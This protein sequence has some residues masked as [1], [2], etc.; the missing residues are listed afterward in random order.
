M[1][2]MNIKLLRF[3]FFIGMGVF[4]HLSYGQTNDLMA[5]VPA[6]A[7]SV[8]V[9]NL[10]N[11]SKK[12]SWESVKQL[13]FF[14]D[15]SSKLQMSDRAFAE[16]LQDPARSGVDFSKMIYMIKTAPDESGAAQTNFLFSLKD[17][18]AFEKLVKTAGQTAGI[19]EKT[20]F[21]QISTSKT[22]YIRVSAH[23]TI[24]PPVSDGGGSNMDSP[25]SIASAAPDSLTDTVTTHTTLAWNS[26]MATVNIVKGGKAG[27]VASFFA[28]TT[29]T[30]GAVITDLTALMKTP[31]DVYNRVDFGSLASNAKNMPGMGAAAGAMNADMFKGD[32]MIG[33]SDF[34]P[35][36]INSHEEFKV[37]S[38]ILGMVAS[39]FKPSTSANF[40]RYFDPSTVSFA[41]SLGVDVSVL[42][43]MI[44]PMMGG[45]KNKMG[46]AASPEDI[47]DALD[48]DIAVVGMKP[49]DP[50]DTTRHIVMAA[51]LKDKDAAMKIL[52]AAVDSGSM[53][54]VSDG[55][56]KMKVPKTAKNSIADK[57]PVKT[58][59]LAVKND[60]VF[61]GEQNDLAN[62]KSNAPQTGANAQAVAQT[63]TNTAFGVFAN[64]EALMMMGGNNNKNPN[65][66]AALQAL[67]HLTMTVKS[68]QS[69]F[70]VSMKDQK[71]NSLQS[72]L[73]VVDAL[74]AAA[75]KNKP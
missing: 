5:S 7:A 57:K 63:L 39:A 14:K 26:K 60:V 21:K 38:M 19:T 75:S 65:L 68:G 64:I 51:S 29:P 46:I 67:D 40:N 70:I 9:I 18:S 73:G 61:F 2:F 20:G 34:E 25:K 62:I 49:T 66:T 35:G 3:F 33:T 12:V 56:Y 27:E 71:T 48:G 30:A 6:S 58:S 16:V 13:H 59:Y 41:A 4:A 47:M 24:E 28:N 37:N 44:G 43:S 74:Y 32:Y 31:H 22:E 36:R 69:D 11:I 8:T 42:K 55:L 50:T 17:A 15:I 10:P 23:K 45:A 72:L 52:N 53:I 54:K 1:N